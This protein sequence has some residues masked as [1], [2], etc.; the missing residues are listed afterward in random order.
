MHEM[1]E[2][3]LKKVNALFSTHEGLRGQPATDAE[4]N[5]A[6]KKLN[7]KFNEQYVEF[8][9]L[10]GGAFG[11][12]DIHAFQNG[13]LIGKATVT[14]MTEKFWSV[15]A[16]NL[17]EELVGAVVISDD[18]SGNPILINTKGEIYIYFHEEDETELLYDSLEAL[19]TQSFP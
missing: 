7:V 9:K 14:E 1:K 2:D 4:I 12:I 6:E 16:D 17:P 19:L 13:S 3:L 8:I 11:G 18:G 15:Y 5:A 10:F